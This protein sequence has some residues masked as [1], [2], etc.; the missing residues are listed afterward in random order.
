[1][2]IEARSA[3]ILFA[4]L[5][6]GVVI[7]ML[8]SGLLQRV[9]TERL[10]E[11]RRPR[12]FAAHMEEIIQ[13]RE[14]QRAAVHQI[15]DSIGRRNDSV[16][17]AA[18]VELRAG[19][20]TMQARLAPLLDDDQRERLARMSRLPDPFRPPPRGGPG[21]PPPREGPPPPP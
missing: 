6:L 21:G 16:I 15:V 20:D 12:G 14:D 8:G 10:G 19:I 2:R 5:A 9:R 13:P 4:T 17:R 18:R 1:M 3:A 7:G 11:L